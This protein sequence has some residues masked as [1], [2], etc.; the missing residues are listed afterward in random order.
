MHVNHIHRS[1]PTAVHANVNG[2]NEKIIS[3]IA[4]NF[5]SCQH[6]HQPKVG[7]LIESKTDWHEK[8]G[9]TDSNIFPLLLLC[10]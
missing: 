1:S 4:C 9:K 5:R 7:K 10:F 2:Q 8:E 6:W 3:R